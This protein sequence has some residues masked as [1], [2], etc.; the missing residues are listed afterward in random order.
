MKRI[1][2]ARDS[3]LDLPVEWNILIMMIISYM[4]VCSV[5][6]RIK[7]ITSYGGEENV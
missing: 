3:L 1:K 2:I 7:P 5:L 4:T 6:N